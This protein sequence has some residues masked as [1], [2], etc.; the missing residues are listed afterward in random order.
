[1]RKHGFSAVEIGTTIEG[2]QLADERFR[3]FLRR[4]RELDV[5]V[6]VHPYYIGAK[7]G[8]ENFY[9]TN[10]IGNPADTTVMVANLMFSGTLE[11]EHFVGWLL[12][13]SDKKVR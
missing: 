6:F 1:V 10:L 4:K 3:P 13:L 11:F 8:L 7:A 9:L 5:L 2:V 12:T